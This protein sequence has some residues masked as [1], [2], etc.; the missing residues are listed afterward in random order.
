[1]ATPTRVRP[2]LESGDHL[3]REEFHARYCERPDIKKAELVEGVVYV[4]S[5]VR[6]R[7]HGRPHGAMM[8]WL[9]TY[10]ATTPDVW[11]LDN[12]T[13]RLD[14]PNEVQPDAILFRE[15]LDGP[16]VTSDDYIEGPP[17]IVVEIAASSVSYDLH[18][19]KEV[20]RRNGVPE[21]VV[22]RTLDGAI[23]WFRL[24]SAQGQYSRVEP[25]E[26]GVI[27]SSMFPGLRLHVPKMLAGDMADV[28]AEL[29]RPP[30]Q[31]PDRSRR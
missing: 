23:D 21:Y 9:G 3:T 2:S 13:L 18:E 6:A 20:Y 25:D 28:L 17:Q 27:E 30:D 7:A 1:M 8:A 14:A 15:G 5:P 24:D 4:A 11:L 26:R 22:W 31:P 16:T 10:Q 19:K 12:A 29:R